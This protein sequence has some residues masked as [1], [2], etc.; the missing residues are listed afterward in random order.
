MPEQGLLLVLDEAYIDDD[1]IDDDTDG[2]N[3][4]DTDDNNDGET[5]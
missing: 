4:D 1:D 2:D 3:D 5:I